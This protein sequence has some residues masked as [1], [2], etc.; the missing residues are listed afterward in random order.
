MNDSALTLSYA[1]VPSPWQLTRLN[2]TALSLGAVLTPVAAVLPDWF[3]TGKGFVGWQWTAVMLVWVISSVIPIAAGIECLRRWRRL[4]TG[5]WAIAL[6]AILLGC[7]NVALGWKM[8]NVA[9]DRWQ[10]RWEASHG[11]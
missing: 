1:R 10:T 2:V 3:N 4:M 9:N 6:L 7:A 8:C 5:G 11:A